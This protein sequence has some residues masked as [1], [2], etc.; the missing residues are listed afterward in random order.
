MRGMLIVCL[1]LLGGT[2]ASLAETLPLRCTF[3]NQGRMNYI[4][5]LDAKTVILF[6]PMNNA[7]HKFVD[8]TGGVRDVSTATREYVIIDDQSIRFGMAQCPSRNWALH[9]KCDDKVIQATSIDRTQ[10][11]IVLEDDKGQKIR[12]QCEKDDAKPK[13]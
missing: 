12:G 1:S 9:L 13:F 6:E 4:V 8:G 3:D 5:D 7:Q 11:T 2:R 10:A